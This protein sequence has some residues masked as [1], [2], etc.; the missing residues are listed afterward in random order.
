M[1]CVLERAE[2]GGDARRPEHVAAEL[3]LETG[4]G[5]ARRKRPRAEVAHS[6]GVG[7]STISLSRLRRPL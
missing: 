3:S 4:L 7:K 6:Y 2:I 5:R 1:A